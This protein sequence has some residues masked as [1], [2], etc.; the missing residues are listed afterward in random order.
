MRI[1]LI[2]DR[3]INNDLDHNFGRMSSWLTRCA[4]LRYDLLCFGESFAQGFDA[5]T[6]Q[7]DR[8]VEIALM[9]NNSHIQKLAETAHACQ[10]GIGFGY[11]ERDE[12]YFY[13]SYMVISNQGNQLVNFRRVS[14]GWKERVSDP[15][16]YQE[17]NAFGSFHL[18]GK[19]IG[20]AICGD[21]WHDELLERFCEQEKDL[22]LWP[23]YINYSPEDWFGGEREEYAKRVAALNRPVLM[24]NSLSDAPEKAYGGAYVFENGIVKQELALGESGI[25]TVTI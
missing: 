2:A 9:Q 16:I 19:N 3:F 23:L 8:D 20:I 21:L 1:G 22:L 6:W 17:G 14:P 11:L 18:E 13:S 24:I 4:G 10:T 5:L 7:P 25:L 12:K 15:G